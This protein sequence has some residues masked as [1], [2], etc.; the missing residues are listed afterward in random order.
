MLPIWSMIGQAMKRR[1]ANWKLPTPAA[2]TLLHLYTHPEDAEPAR[3]SE[4][5]GIPR[6]TMTFT[7]DALEKQKLATRKSHPNDRRRKIISLSDK[8][9]KFAD[10]MLQDLRKFEAQALSEFTTTEFTTLHTLT[11]KFADALQK[12]QS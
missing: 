7:L 10:A 1:I 5:I 12:T 9:K 8:G 4:S 2:F 11:Q 3:L 6:Q